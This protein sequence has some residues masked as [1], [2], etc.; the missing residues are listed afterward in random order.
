MSLV[1]LVLFLMVS[2]LG[3]PTIQ[4]AQNED[5]EQMVVRLA[6][7]SKL[8]P[9]Y[10]A[11]FNV[12]NPKFDREYVERLE[13]VLSFDLSHNGMTYLVERKPEKELLANARAFEEFGSQA[14]WQASHVFY[15]VKGQLK[16]NALS[17]KV[18]SVH[19]NTIKSIDN[20]VLTGDL[21][22]D[23]T[24]IHLLADLIHKELFGTNGI[25]STHILYS[26]SM[27]DR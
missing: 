13:Q 6:T 1:Y 23:R 19:T 26:V 11:K 27:Q 16:E 2:F 9:L 7:E 20:I 4:A 14:N 22:Q 21:S 25:A 18:Y 10:L 17:L 8:Q 24:Q 15:V 3:V 12:L 5:Q